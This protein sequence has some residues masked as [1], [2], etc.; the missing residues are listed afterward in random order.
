MAGKITD[1]QLRHWIRAGRPLAKAQGDVPGLTFTLSST[2]AASWVL[3]YRFGGK[4]RELTIGRYPDFGIAAA[5]AAALEARAKIQSGIDVARAKR[6]EH[7]QRAGAQTVKDLCDDYMAKVMPTLAANTRTNRT[8]HIENHVIPALGAIPA[9]ELTGADIVALL[10]KVGKKSVSMATLVRVAINEICKHGIGR[11]VMTMNPCAGIT[12]KAVC[13]EGKPKRARLK[14]TEEELRILLPALPGLASRQVVLAIKL[15]LMTC[16]RINELLRANWSDVDIGA[17]A[18]RIPDEHS[19]TGDGFT[20]PLSKQAVQLFDELKVLSC[21]S[22]LVLPGQ[23]KR[24]AHRSAAGISGAIEIICAKLPT[25][26]RFTPHDLRSTAR[27]HLAALG[28]P[29][30]VAERCL[31]HSLGGLVAVYDQ[32]DYF[33]ERR[34]A[35]ALLGDFLKACEAGTPWTPAEGNV[36]PIRHVR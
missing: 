4:A 16:V 3:R 12:V 27:S 2:G 33:D 1:V 11:R 24:Q 15:M 28:V 9:R 19:K 7:V 10:E 5:K 32:H 8:H 35:L 6:L 20:I 21:G 23:G 31:N 36:V 34:R 17:A 13:G 25:V 18:W 22:P 29:I 30:L 14:L 26:R